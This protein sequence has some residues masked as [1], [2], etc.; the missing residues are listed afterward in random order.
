MASKK[1]VTN[2]QI[3]LAWMLKK[4]PNV[5]LIPGSKKKVELLKT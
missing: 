4:Y 5:V 1:N 2:A 3:S